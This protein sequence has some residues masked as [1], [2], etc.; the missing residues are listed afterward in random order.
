MKSMMKEAEWL[1][2]ESVPTL[3]EYMENGYVSFALGPIILPALYFVGPKLSEGVIRDLEYHTLF[4]LVSTCGRLLNDVQGFERERKE[5]KLNSLS[6]RILYSGGSIS[7]DSAKRETENIISSTRIELLRLVLQR[8]E[9]VVPR[10]CKELFWKMSKV[11]HLFYLRTDG[12]TSPKEMMA[13][14][15]AVIHEPLKVGHL[16]LSENS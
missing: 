15:N 16:Q 9:S 3:D 13:A 11:L 2:N 1:W 12:F 8:E 6:L 14:V 10:D 4:R 5:G 7:E